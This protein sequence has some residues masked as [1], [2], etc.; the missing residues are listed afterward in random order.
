MKH[1]SYPTAKAFLEE[2]S[3]LQSDTELENTQRF[4]RDEGSENKLMGIR[5]ANLFALAKKFI[6]MP[7][8]EIELL[9][10]NEYYEARMGA[11]CIMDFQARDNKTTAEQRKALFDLYIS[12]HSFINNW[13]MVDRSAPYVVGG[14]LFDKPREILYSLAKSDN[15]WERR[16][17]I[18]ATYYFIRQNDVEDTF[19]IAELLVHDEHDLVQKAVG[20]WIREAGKRDEGRLLDFLDRYSATMPRVMLRHAIE[21]LDKETREQYLKIATNC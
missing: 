3:P 8:S 17:A 12:K 19:K 20:S 6:T 9:L 18:V 7:I 1:P 11:V 10:E 16:T 2:L 5:M 14:Y 15:V 13:D 21:K 4:F